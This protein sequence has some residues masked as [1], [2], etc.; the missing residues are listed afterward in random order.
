M[1]KNKQMQP[2]TA[3]TSQPKS[4]PT[5]PLDDHIE[6]VS[7]R[8]PKYVPIQETKCNAM[9]E[10]AVLFKKEYYNEYCYLE[11]NKGTGRVSITLFKSDWKDFEKIE[12]D[13]LEGFSFAVKDK[14][15]TSVIMNTLV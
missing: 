1:S 2:G 12:G 8:F 3:S 11:Y 7:T 9:K 5:L 10:D 14:S 15:E 6:I 4:T 13:F